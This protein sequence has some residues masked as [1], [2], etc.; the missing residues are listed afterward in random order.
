[1][2]DIEELKDDIG[3]LEGIIVGALNDISSIYGVKPDDEIIVLLDEEGKVVDVKINFIV[4]GGV[5]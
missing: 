3:Q 4:N 5:D 1:M 2:A